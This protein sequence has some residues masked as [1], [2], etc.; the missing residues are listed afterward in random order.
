MENEQ[1][2]KRRHSSR[3]G[4][5]GK[6]MDF[7][8]LTTNGRQNAQEATGSVVSVEDEQVPSVWELQ[9]GF[10]ATDFQQVNKLMKAAEE[11]LCCHFN[12]SQ[13]VAAHIVSVFLQKK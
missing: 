7:R 5:A 11:Q 9:K 1:R 3:L 2:H 10:C 4:S 13:V 6:K 12:A 8:E